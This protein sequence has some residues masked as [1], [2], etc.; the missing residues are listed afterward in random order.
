MRSK[1]LLD[2]E[3]L[4]CVPVEVAGFWTALFQQVLTKEFADAVFTRHAGEIGTRLSREGKSWPATIRTEMMLVRDTTSSEGVKIHTSNPNNLVTFLFYLPPDDRY[5]DC[6]TT[7]YL[8]KE[9]GF[10]C[11]GGPHHDF[12]RFDKVW[13]APFRANALLMFVK[14]DDS[15]H[16][17][18][19]LPAGIRRD[20]LLFYIGR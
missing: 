4:A 13:T 3:H 16:G 18:E 17:V 10:R 8:P 14:S 5:V 7:L 1:F 19:P 6:G 20:V 15:F 2:D 9:R 11:W 12:S